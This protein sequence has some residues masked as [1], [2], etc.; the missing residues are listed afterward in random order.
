MAVLFGHDCLLLAVDLTSGGP[1]G[2]ESS[3]FGRSLPVARSRKRSRAAV[4]IDL[5]W[6]GDG[7]TVTSENMGQSRTALRDRGTTVC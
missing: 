2:C 3:A 6:I 5:G 1:R 4:R 7:V